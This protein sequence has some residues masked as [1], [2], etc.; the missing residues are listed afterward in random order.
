MLIVAS[1]V[2]IKTNL[3][4]QDSD[5]ERLHIR[6]LHAK[7]FAVVSLVCSNA[8]F[9]WHIAR[10]VIL[11]VCEC[12]CEFSATITIELK[13]YNLCALNTLD[14][15]LPTEVAQDGLFIAIQ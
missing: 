13:V 9:R 6:T 7:W 8:H 15:S 5:R 1:L 14:P 3:L 11:V 10:G 12:A 2:A 4:A